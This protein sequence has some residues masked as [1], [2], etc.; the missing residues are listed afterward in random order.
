MVNLDF[1]AIVRRI[2]KNALPKYSKIAAPAVECM[3]DCVSGFIS[4]N[5]SER[6]RQER[7]K[8]GIARQ[9]SYFG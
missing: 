1:P 9:R 5:T 7:K 4:F 3:Q 2:M 8:K 6:E